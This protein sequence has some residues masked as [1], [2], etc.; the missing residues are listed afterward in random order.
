ME[1]WISYSDPIVFL[2][3][4]KKLNFSDNNRPLNKWGWEGENPI[5]W[6]K[7]KAYPLALR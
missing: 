2:K 4:S 3:Y 6:Q 1:L 5:N 7:Q